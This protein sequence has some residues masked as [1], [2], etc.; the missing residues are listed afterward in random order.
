MHDD[1]VR[2][3]VPSSKSLNPGLDLSSQDLVLEFSWRPGPLK[4][5]GLGHV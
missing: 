5:F 4:F 2:L 1:M 3:E